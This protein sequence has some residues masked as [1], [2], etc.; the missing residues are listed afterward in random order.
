MDETQHAFVAACHGWRGD[1]I[2]AGAHIGKVKALAPSFEIETFLATMH[3]AQEE[4]LQHLREGLVKA[5][6]G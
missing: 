6:A 2:A 4:D 1:A 3:Y 5:G